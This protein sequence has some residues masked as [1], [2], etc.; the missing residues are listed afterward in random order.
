MPLYNSLA[1]ATATAVFVPLP[2]CFAISFVY[3]RYML[4]SQVQIVRNMQSGAQTTRTI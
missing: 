3:K 2:L 4:E 1:G